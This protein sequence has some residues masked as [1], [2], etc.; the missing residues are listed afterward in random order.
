[1]QIDNADFISGGSDTDHR[2]LPNSNTDEIAYGF[3][4]LETA[5]SAASHT[6]DYDGHVGNFNALQRYED[7]LIVAFTTLLAVGTTTAVRS[8]EES[9]TVSDGTISTGLGAV[10]SLTESITV[11]DGTVSVS[12]QQDYTRPLTESITVSDG[13]RYY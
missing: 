12:T 6:I 1:M 8:L 3:T 11:A 13:N 10:R 7:R 9:I 2:N 5:L 4:T